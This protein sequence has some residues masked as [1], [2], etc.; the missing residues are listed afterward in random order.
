MKPL[1]AESKEVEIDLPRGEDGDDELATES[2][3]GEE[4][5]NGGV[6]LVVGGLRG[7]EGN[8]R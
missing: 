2:R 3:I 5:E 8:G 4:R 1:T 7:G 6:D